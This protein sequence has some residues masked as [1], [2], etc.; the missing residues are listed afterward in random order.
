MSE[1]IIIHNGEVYDGIERIAEDRPG[2]LV[3]RYVNRRPNGSI[4]S[5]ITSYRPILTEEE[6]ERRMKLIAEAA[7]NLLINLYETQAREAAQKEK[8][9]NKD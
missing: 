6:R 1:E 9:R 8:A 5:Y 2:Y 4:S 7:A 3:T